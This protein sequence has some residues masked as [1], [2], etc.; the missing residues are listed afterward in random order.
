V[1]SNIRSDPASA[2]LRRGRQVTI[3]AWVIVLIACDP[4]RAPAADSLRGFIHVAGQRL[5]APDG[6]D[7]PIR[8]IG[9]GST[10]A[11]PVEKDYAEIARLN[12][13]TVTVMLGY[14]RFYAEDAPDNYIELGRKRLDQHL[15][16]ARKYGLRVILQMLSVEGA[17][18]VPSKGEAFDYRIWV[19]PQLQERFLKLWE[20]IAGRYKDES[21]ILGYGIFC[22]PVVSGT[23]QQWIDLAN[24]AVARI[25]N[26]DKNHILF[27]ERLYGEFGTR[28]EMSGLDL[29][30][31]RAFFV[32]PDRNVVYQFY[33]F[34]RDEYTH[35]HAPWREDRDLD[36]RYPEPRFEI[37][38]REAVNDRGRVFR[39]DK[40][41]LNFY[42]NRQLEFGAKHKVPMF[43]WAFGLLKNCF[44]GQGGL[45]WLRDT[46]SLFNDRHLSWS[47]IAYRDDDNGISDNEPAQKILAGSSRN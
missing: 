16:L 38:Y 34:E 9:A 32:V 29:N 17:Q 26:V 25:R 28:R 44:A 19:Q 42:L 27:V 21:Q 5:V 43:V 36:L 2:G 41:Y 22:E 10:G 12:F 33:F 45:E 47:Y 3:C 30:P 18:F 46:K 15:A 4:G 6:D 13:N 40:Q 1:T 35:Q 39:L 24:K 37:V 8:A 20:A 11:D 31:E 23:R 7:F 14:R